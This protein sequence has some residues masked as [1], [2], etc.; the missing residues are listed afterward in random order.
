MTE[1]IRLILLAHTADFQSV[2]T[3]HV[4]I[5]FTPQD[6]WPYYYPNIAK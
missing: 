2:G 6:D 1:N 4:Q 3:N 5:S